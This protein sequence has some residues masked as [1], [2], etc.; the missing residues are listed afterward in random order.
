MA[1]TILGYSAEEL[2]G[3]NFHDLIHHHHRDGT[4]YHKEDCSIC[5]TLLNG[6][7]AHGEDYFWRKDGTGFPIEYSCLPIV[8]EYAITGAVLT[9]RDITA[10]KSAEEDARRAYEILEATLDAMPDQLFDVGLDGYIY[11]VHSPRTELL[12]LPAADIIGKIIPDILPP[13]IS[14]VLM[15]AIKE[16]NDKGYSSGKQYE[17][18]VPMGTRWFE[19]SVSRKV[20]APDTAQHFIILRRDIT[21]SKMVYNAFRRSEAIL[22]KMV[23]KF[24][25]VVV[26]LDQ[27]GVNRYKSPNIEKYFGWK[28][29]E[30]VGISTWE[31][32]HPED[33]V[34]TQKFVGDLIDQPNAT[35][36]AKCRYRC[37]DGSYRKIEITVVN[38]LH[39]PDIRGLLGNYHEI[40]KRKRT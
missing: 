33:R 32:V 24:G 3:K 22:H 10:R 9:F 1:V 19:I 2:M 7:P 36:T 26:L 35:G 37:K 12:N 40:T 23:S 20:N 14:D 17:L 6:K 39:D 28:P 15:A 21:E 11:N 29:E 34:S 4:V 18:K 25:A 5:N 31:M 30:V 38:L 16:A 27:D 13:D 8:E